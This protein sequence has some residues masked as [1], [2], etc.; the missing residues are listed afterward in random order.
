MLVT[1]RNY[2]IICYQLRNSLFTKVDDPLKR[3][4]NK[5]TKEITSRILSGN[6]VEPEFRELFPLV[7]SI[8]IAAFKI[9]QREKNLN[10]SELINEV[11][12]QIE[13]W[14]SVKKLGVLVENILFALRCNKRVIDA[15]INEGDVSDD[16]LFSGI[17]QLPIISY[18][19]FLTAV[20][21]GSPSNEAAQK[22]VDWT[23]ASLNIELVSIAADIIKDKK[24]DVSIKKINELAF[25]VANAGQEYLA[26]AMELGF[27]KNDPT[28]N[29][30]TEL[31]FSKSFI[32]EQ[33]RLADLD[34][35]DLRGDIK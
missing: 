28:Q 4:L 10:L 29:D 17:S 19:Q 16:S 23:A 15:L 6:K 21:L 25:L 32:N 24:L 1:A 8:R 7:F 12:A 2:D 20:A 13:E 27:L 9:L 30:Y 5:L 31:S 33:K 35:N 18:E 11:T 3:S 14:K 22:I 26:I 34:L